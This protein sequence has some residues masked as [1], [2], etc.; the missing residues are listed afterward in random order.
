MEVEK[1]SSET[2]IPSGEG[3]SRGQK[4]LPSQC[5]PEDTS[6][7]S[8]KAALNIPHSSS[9]DSVSTT[10]GKDGLEGA[11][12]ECEGVDS[13]SSVQ[14][15]TESSS[16]IVGPPSSTDADSG[17]T[18]EG[19]SVGSSQ[20]EFFDAVLAA[21]STETESAKSHKAK[22]SSPPLD[23]A[24]AESCE[25]LYQSA[26]GS[27]EGERS[28]MNMEMEQFSSTMLEKEGGSSTEQEARSS[29]EV[30]PTL[31][32]VAMETIMVGEEQHPREAMPTINL[33][34]DTPTNLQDDEAVASTDKETLEEVEPMEGVELSREATP[35]WGKVMADAMMKGAE[36]SGET[37]PSSE[38]HVMEPMV[39]GA[40]HS[41]ESTPTTTSE[42][43]GSGEA[44]PTVT[45]TMVEEEERLKEGG[46]RENSVESEQQRGEVRW[47]SDI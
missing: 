2:T 30:T 13:L 42:E 40:E 3:E 23:D 32:K 6:L 38:E 28:S 19:C 11:R 44:T 26:A 46:S 20:E 7:L 10:K 43:A 31:E 21:M 9:E 1:C 18:Q 35:T 15:A 25:T 29:R 22:E 47:N 4:P 33:E 24:S 17:V 45:E 5:I 12:M 8:S 27:Y 36:I 41:G 39:E 14:R 34:G 16:V 37:T